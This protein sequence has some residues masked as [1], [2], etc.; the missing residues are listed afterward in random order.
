MKRLF[1]VIMA[2]ALLAAFG[3]A[4]AVEGMTG[5][6]TYNPARE[7]YEITLTITTKT[8]G[9]LTAMSTDDVTVDGKTVTEWIKWKYLYEVHAKTGTL[10]A[11]DASDLIIL[12]DDS[13]GLLGSP[14]GGTTAY[15]G[16][17]IFHATLS[18]MTHPY[19]YNTSAATYDKHYHLITGALTLDILNNSV[20]TANVIVK[21]IVIP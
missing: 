20:N 6:V 14:D 19:Y 18:K 13:M 2:F 4:W 15:G 9:S 12:D 17:D 8:D 16:T 5:A 10:A 21:L 1:L 7:A 3:S 11:T